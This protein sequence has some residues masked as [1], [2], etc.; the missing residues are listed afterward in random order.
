MAQRYKNYYIYR[1]GM[2]TPNS[3]Q[4]S[5]G[6]KKTFGQKLSLVIWLLVLS[7]S[8]YIAYS[9]HTQAIT[10]EREATI[11]QAAKRSEAQQ[12][13]AA[14]VQSI[15]DNDPTITYSVSA[16]DVSSGSSV[17]VGSGQPMNAASCAKI[18][19]AALFLHEAENG[20]TSLN[21]YLGG[22]TSK[23][24]LRRLVQQSDDNAWVLFNDKL[25]HPALAAYAQN[26]GLSSYDPD[27]NTISAQ[28]MSALLQKLYK[29]DLLNQSY[30]NLLLSYMQNT[31]YEQFIVPAVPTNYN[32][33]HKVGFVD[34]EINDAAIITNGKQ[35]ITLSI[36]SNGKDI[37][38]QYARAQTIQ[39]ITKA[40]LNL[41]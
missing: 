20:Q 3:R 19:T 38:D 39:Q 16:V 15:L 8:I 21:S 7:F 28:D 27:T 40:A 11:A 22:H 31:N 10:N 33:Y 5:K 36:F 29:G 26:L 24:Q 2:N 1:P 23:Y 13:F 35:S 9:K 14:A 34:G 17:K 37:F 41:L 25:T 30:T 4:K 18:L 32:V 12:Q 6:T